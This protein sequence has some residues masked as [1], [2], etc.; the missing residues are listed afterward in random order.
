[1]EGRIDE[2]AA[3]QNY[4]DDDFYLDCSLHYNTVQVKAD[5]LDSEEKTVLDVKGNGA[6]S[7]VV[8]QGNNYLIYKI[9]LDEVLCFYSNN[10]AGT[11]NIYFGVQ[12]LNGEGSA[13]Q[14]K[15]QKVSSLNRDFSTTSTKYLNYGMLPI[16]KNRLRVVAA[17]TSAGTGNA[18]TVGYG[19]GGAAV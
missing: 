19:I 11:S 2:I 9:Y 12:T 15:S 3:K 13:S 7:V 14:G 4:T 10:S 17:A 18:L 1:M 6:L 5:Q 16:F 8:A